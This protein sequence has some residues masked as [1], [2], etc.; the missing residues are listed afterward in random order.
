MRMKRVFLLLLVLSLVVSCAACGGKEEN[1]VPDPNAVTRDEPQ[2]P[3]IPEGTPE[4]T[5][6]PTGEKGREAAE[7][8]LGYVDPKIGR[9][10]LDDVNE[11]VGCRL[12]VPE[13]FTFTEQRFNVIDDGGMLIAE[14]LFRY[15]GA[16]FCLRAADEISDITGRQKEGVPLGDAED[17]DITPETYENGYWAR[18][19]QDNMQYCI[20]S[21]NVTE[22]IFE[23]VY[24]ALTE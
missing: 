4:E 12:T 2:V 1:Q 18:W 11:A 15:D 6:E 14:F 7:P 24:R 3:G 22:D 20:I 16:D 17:R 23:T 10:T 21:E 13:G 5:G 8:I 9:E 19:F